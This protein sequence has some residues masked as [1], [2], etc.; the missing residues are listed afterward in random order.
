MNM[1]RKF[2]LLFVTGNG[3]VFSPSLALPDELMG[4]EKDVSYLSLESSD[5]SDPDSVKSFSS[6]IMKKNLRHK[7]RS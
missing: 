3:Y 6:Y 1:M 7:V 2:L 4:N 5:G